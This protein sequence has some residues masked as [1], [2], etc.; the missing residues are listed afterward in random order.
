MLKDKKGIS[1][2]ILVL[3]IVIIVAI[4]ATIAFLVVNKNKEGTNINNNESL[5]QKN[6]ETPKF[7]NLEYEEGYDF[8]G[9]S[10][11]VKIPEMLP[12]TWEEANIE[13]NNFYK[14]NTPLTLDTDK[15][16]S[17]LKSNSYMKEGYE[18]IRKLQS[19]KHQGINSSKNG[20]Y[21]T[22]GYYD[23]ILAS[24]K[25]T[26]KANFTVYTYYNLELYNNPSIISLKME[27]V[28]METFTQEKFYS[29]AKSVFGD[30]ADYLVFG[31]DSDGVSPKGK[32]LSHLPDM[33]DIIE[34][35][36]SSYKFVRTIS[37][38]SDY[39]TANIELYIEV[40]ENPKLGDESI[41]SDKSKLYETIKYTPSNIFSKSFGETN[42][43]NAESFGMD[44]FKTVMPGFNNSNLDY[45]NIST[46]THE[47]GTIDYS[48]GIKT[49]NLNSTENKGAISYII[50]VSEK[51]GNITDFYLSTS[52]DWK[53]KNTNLYSQQYINDCIKLAKIILPGLE[54]PTIEYNDGVKFYK[55][56]I[57]YN[58]NGNV[59]NGTFSINQGS[60][61]YTIILSD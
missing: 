4:G 19:E 59:F 53:G 28:N 14:T 20:F 31:K 37:Y 54:I 49:R 22:Y 60:Y 11:D 6:D 7:D 51:D 45:W 50:N 16:L 40:S 23:Y 48:F 47:D 57:S 25:G 13:G 3:V 26:D 43:L 36:D 58:F 46:S 5:A 1:L 9:L 42:P 17:E 2:I 27:N 29:I 41:F 35:S 8:W 32:K 12:L 39:N 52:T 21:I 38:S 61:T 56:N 24:K 34:S 10:S 15:L 44:Y 33:I 55:T 30:N 18:D